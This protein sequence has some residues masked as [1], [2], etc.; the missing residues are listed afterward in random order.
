LKP[1]LLILLN[2]L[3]I[4]GPAS[5]TLALA[6]ALSETYEILLVAGHPLPEEASAAYLLNHYQG[7][8]HQLLPEIQRAVR[9][10]QDLRTYRKLKNII[11]EFK[12]NIVHTH[13]SKPGIL[14]RWAASWCKVPLIVHTYHGHVFRS[15]FSPFISG[16]IIQLERFLAKRT[17]LILAINEHLQQELIEKFKIADSKKI[18][19]NRL[20]VDAAMYEDPDG[21]K[22]NQFRRFYHLEDQTVAIAIVG[23]L[24]KIKQH[25][26]FL[27]VAFRLLEQTVPDKQFCFFIVGD[28]EEYQHLSEKI[29]HAQYRCLFKGDAPNGAVDFVFTSWRKDIEVV[30]AGMDIL[31]M[32][33]INE[34][35][36]VAILEA[37]AAGKPVV[38][39]PVGG[40]PELLKAAGSGCTCT[41]KE[42]MVQQIIKWSL[43][44][45]T[46]KSNTE[47]GRVYVQQ[48]LSVRQQA[49]SLTELF[50]ETGRV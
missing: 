45:E 47:K 29:Q 48:H 18:R 40:I 7:F 24:V 10:M 21:S 33:S 30:M 22:R 23:R 17:H 20:G 46:L 2:R 37:L 41:D 38:S 27:E 42:E 4:G 28:G 3:S 11:R 15:Y 12:P 14:G 16:C 36:P 32:T 6:S 1:R 8:R 31:L 43:S 39:T 49:E 34:G 35:T 19:L 25:T 9:P 5:N 50:R 13:G 26:L 44:P